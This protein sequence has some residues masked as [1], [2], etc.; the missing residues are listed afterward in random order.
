MTYD[1]VVMAGGMLDPLEWGEGCPPTKALLKYGNETL[2]GVILDAFMDV[3][4]IHSRLV[5]GDEPE[6]GLIARRYGAYSIPTGQGLVGNLRNALI[7]LDSSPAAHIIIAASDIPL[8]TRNAA[9]SLVGEFDTLREEFDFVYPVVPVEDCLRI[10]P[11]GKRTTVKTKDGRFT[12]G[13]V[14]L[15]ERRRLLENIPLIENLVRYRKSPVKLA[16]LIGFG[17]ILK[18][19]SGS[20]SLESYAESVNRRI[21]GSVTAH[22][23]SYPEIAIDIDSADQFSKISQVSGVS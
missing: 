8:M 19:I 20:G 16:S 6:I 1:L 23:C 11:G 18:V 7:E 2:L 22:V 14:F 4:G 12:G 15:A 10:M 17:T 3:P 13:N 5:I 21:K 9:N